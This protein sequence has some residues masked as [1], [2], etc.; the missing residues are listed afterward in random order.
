MKSAMRV[1]VKIVLLALVVLLAQMVFA[2]LVRRAQSPTLRAQR[3]LLANLE[4]TRLLGTNA[5]YV[6]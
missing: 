1:P 6:V 4:C 2:H 3:A 5:C